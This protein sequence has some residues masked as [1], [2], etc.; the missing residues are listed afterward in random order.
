MITVDQAEIIEIAADGAGRFKIGMD[1][2][3]ATLREG[4]AA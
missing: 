4:G 3:I 1:G 2:E